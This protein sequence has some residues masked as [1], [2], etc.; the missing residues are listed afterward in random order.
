MGLKSIDKF[1][2]SSAIIGALYFPV[3]LG[4]GY[5]YDLLAE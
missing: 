2:L 5:M 1:T 4:I 3:M